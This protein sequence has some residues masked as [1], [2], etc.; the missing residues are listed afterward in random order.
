MTVT[1]ATVDFYRYIDCTELTRITID[2]IRETIE[3]E[4]PSELRYLRMYD[5]ILWNWW[6]ITY[7]DATGTKKNSPRRS[8]PPRRAPT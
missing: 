5:E 3:T 7:L 2:F 1:N 4:L 6:T 8:K